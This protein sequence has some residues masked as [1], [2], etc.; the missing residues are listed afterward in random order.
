M[1]GSDEEKC[2][3]TGIII[4]TNQVSQ[5]LSNYLPPGMAES[6]TPEQR[7]NA[8]YG[9]KMV[10][11]LEQCMLATTWLIKACLLLMYSQLT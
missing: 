10:V 9:S 1:N 7:D 2:T 6:F 3:F 5:N 8:I 4:A 11:V